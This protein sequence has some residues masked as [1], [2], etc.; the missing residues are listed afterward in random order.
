MQEAYRFDER[1]YDAL[2]A[3]AVTWQTVQHV[4]RNRPRVRRHIGAVLHIA[5]QGPDRRWY[6]VALVEEAA[7]EYLVV[8]A[9]RL[10]DT[11]I[12][13]VSKMLERGAP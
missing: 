13:A 6:M 3:A 9:R 12:Q 2:D 10:D 5:G 1:S 11:E 7:D 4:L 8:G